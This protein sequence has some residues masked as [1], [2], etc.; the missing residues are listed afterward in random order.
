MA[1]GNLSGGHTRGRR[2][3][4]DI[5]VTPLVDIMLVLLIIFMVTATYIVRDSMEVKLPEA[6]TGESKATSLLALIVYA[7]GKLALNG[8]PSD[9]GKVR[10][11]IRDRRGKG[12]ALE[13]IIAADRAVPHG[14]VVQV[15]DLVRAEG[16]IKFAINVLKPEK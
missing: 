6:S 8:E 9:E 13:A 1:G 4:T 12:D 14:R 15:L 3:I 5:N 2:L 7:D 16:V 11:F 10:A